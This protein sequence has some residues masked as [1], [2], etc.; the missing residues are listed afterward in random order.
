MHLLH[1][2]G[3]CSL[4]LPLFRYSLLFLLLGTL[5]SVDTL[6]SQIQEMTLLVV[7]DL[8]KEEVESVQ[9]ISI[10]SIAIKDESTHVLS[11]SSSEKILW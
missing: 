7:V 11:L 2:H 4:V 6:G 1:L 3:I 5:G 10:I 9:L 8:V